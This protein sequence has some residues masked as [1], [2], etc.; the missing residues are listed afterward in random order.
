MDSGMHPSSL[1]ARHSDYFYA[2]DDMLY[3]LY[4][5]EGRTLRSASSFVSI[6]PR[7]L[8]SSSFL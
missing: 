1:L 4:M 5:G 3:L 2:I 8:S 6:H 7:M